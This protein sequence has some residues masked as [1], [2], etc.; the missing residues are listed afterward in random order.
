M[1]SKRAGK[2][3]G[4][5]EAWHYVNLLLNNPATRQKIYK[6]YVEHHKKYKGA[7]YKD[8]EEAMA[9]DFRRYV[10]MMD[11]TGLSSRI[12]RFFNNILDF[13]FAARKTTETRM[14]FEAIRSGKA[15]GMRIDPE[16]LKEF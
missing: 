2:G 7:K 16:S 8:I 11:G 3:I 10:Q 5:H 13:L 15:K 9:E 14:I 6:D 1:F 4:Y 12:K